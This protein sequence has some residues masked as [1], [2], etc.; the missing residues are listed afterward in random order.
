[1][2]KLGTPIGAGPGSESEK[3]G[4]EADGTPLPVGSAT[5][6]ALALRWSAGCVGVGEVVVVCRWLE[7][8]CFLVGRLGAGLG[9][10]LE[11]D[12]VEVELEVELEDEDEELELGLEP[13]L[14]E[15]DPEPLGVLLA[16]VVVLAE[17]VLSGTQLSVSETVPGT[18]GTLRFWT[19][20]PGGTLGNTNVRVCP[21]TIVT[22]TVQV[23][24]EAAGAVRPARAIRRLPASA[25][26]TSS[27]RLLTWLPLLPRSRCSRHA[28]HLE[29]AACVHDTRQRGQEATDCSGALQFGTVTR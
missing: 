9:R 26:T 28:W 6:L 17:L 4:L 15:L 16:L 25:S 27:F 29:T 24:A 1:M 14:L 12:E 7:G 8:F 23:S 3:L 10:V 13:E 18:C 20:V 5:F 2:K 21:P 11:D 19:G 22:E